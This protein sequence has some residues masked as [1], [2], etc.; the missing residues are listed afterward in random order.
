M[1]VRDL[2]GKE[3]MSDPNSHTDANIDRPL[4]IPW[5]LYLAC[6]AAVFTFCV[7]C[8]YKVLIDSVF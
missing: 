2:S 1:A 4:F 5:T 3:D 6:R 7:D 8:H